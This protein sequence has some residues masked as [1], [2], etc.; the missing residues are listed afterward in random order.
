M[1]A[2]TIRDEECFLSMVMTATFHSTASVTVVAL[3]LGFV[4][5]L[6]ADILGTRRFGR[7]LC[8]HLWYKRGGRKK[9]SCGPS[10]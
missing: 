6:K 8:V 1:S 5:C 7:L 3:Q 9:P 10:G 2:V 4:R